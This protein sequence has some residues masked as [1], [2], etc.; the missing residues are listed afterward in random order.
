MQ[1]KDLVRVPCESALSPEQ[2]ARFDVFVAE[3]SAQDATSPFSEQTLVALKQAAKSGD[4]SAR[5]FYFLDEALTIMAAWVVLAPTASTPGL[6]EGATHPRYRRSGCAAHTTGFMAADLDI[7]RAPYQLWVH[8]VLEDPEGEIAAGARHLAQKYGFK[9]V[10]ELHKMALN[11]TEDSRA[12]LQDQARKAPL[13]T[14]IQLRTYSPQDSLAWLTLNAAAF[15]SHP[16]QGQLSQADLDERLAAPWF[17]SEGFFLAQAP[18]GL[19]GYHWTKI[20]PAPASGPSE[21]EV[22]AVG[23]SPAWQGKGLGKA[24]T[25]AGM[26]YLSRASSDRGAPLDRIVLYVDADNTPAMN[27]YR[28]LGFQDLTIDHMYSTT[29]QA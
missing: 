11:L 23:V 4:G 20:P 14:G 1:V 13:P 24:L 29:A 18:N 21:G 9:P 25:L 3:V 16:E 10:R 15:A 17:R 19:A 22:Y 8:Q 27:L 6:I 7:R 26:D 28:S 5:L 12:L 2:L